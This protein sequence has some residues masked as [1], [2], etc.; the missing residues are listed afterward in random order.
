MAVG[1]NTRGRGVEG[2]EGEGGH[3]DATTADPTWHAVA[4]H[5]RAPSSGMMGIQAANG[6]RRVAAAGAAL[7]LVCGACAVVSMAG[8]GGG[9]GGA[10][11]LEASGG[12]MFDLPSSKVMS[13]ER[14]ELDERLGASS[15]GS[16]TSSLYIPDY[17]KAYDSS[18]EDNMADVVKQLKKLGESL[19]LPSYVPN[20]AA[21]RTFWRSEETLFNYVGIALR[22]KT[23]RH[24]L[25]P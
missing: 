11:V 1:G 21:K 19:P 17:W 14:R 7:L 18:P 15:Q 4:A 23:R 16:A 3:V 10:S 13:M 2:W 9:G 22:K 24:Q 5:S 20:V 8:S 12:R 6:P 25:K